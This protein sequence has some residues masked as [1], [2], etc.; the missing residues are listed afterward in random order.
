MS[1]SSSSHCRRIAAASSGA[2]TSPGACG[3][4]SNLSSWRRVR[5]MNA[6]PSAKVMVAVFSENPRTVE[7][8]INTSPGDGVWGAFG[9]LGYYRKQPFLAIEFGASKGRTTGAETTVLDPGT[10]ALFQLVRHAENGSGPCVVGGFFNRGGQPFGPFE[11]TPGEP[12]NGRAFRHGDA[13]RARQDESQG[14]APG[15]GCHKSF[16]SNKASRLLQGKG[17]KN[18]RFAP[19][20]ILLRRS[21]SRPKHCLGETYA[22]HF[23]CLPGCI[24]SPS[25]LALSFVAR[26]QLAR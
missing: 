6:R 20:K 16:T 13:L 8:V 2:I 14:I 21:Q 5:S 3:R 18:R 11:P 9:H 23:Y 1:A 19:L 7:R 26:G 10:E 4:A 17:S 24:V 15:P 12:G 22:D 25:L